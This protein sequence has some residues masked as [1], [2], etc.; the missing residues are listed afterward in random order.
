MFTLFTFPCQNHKERNKKF[1]DK[2]TERKLN[3]ENFFPKKEKKEARRSTNDNYMKNFSTSSP[4][5]FHFIMSV[6]ATRRTFLDNERK[7]DE[8]NNFLT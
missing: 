6:C 1:G 7:E 4:I 5:Q 3:D 8:K 2:L